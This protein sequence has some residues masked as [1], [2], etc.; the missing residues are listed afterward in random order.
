MTAFTLPDLGEGLADATVLRW[1]VQPG[2]RVRRGDT[3]LDVETAKAVVE[4]PAPADGEVLA[5][6]VNAGDTVP[7]GSVLLEFAE[8]A[9]ATGSQTTR[10]RGKAAVPTANAPAATQ[11][12]AHGADT[13]RDTTG[14]T[15]SQAPDQS[16]RDQ[17]SVVGRMPTAADTRDDSF[18]VGRHRHTEAR[19]Q[20]TPARRRARTTAEAAPE[21]PAAQ[22]ATAT[23]APPRS[24]T[25][26][27]NGHGGAALSPLRARMARQL[28]ACRA[29][30]PVTIF[31]EAEL[32]FDAAQLLSARLLRALVAGAQA[33]PAL[34]A[35]FDGATLHSTP[36]A[37]V[38]VGLAVDTADGLVVPVLRHAE[39]LGLAGLQRRVAKLKKAAHAGTL[40]PADMT[41]AT[42]SLSNFGAIAGR[43]ATPLV[44][45][46]QVAILGAG[47]AY[48]GLRMGR[49]KLKPCLRLPLS[50]SVD[51]R[52]VTGGEAARFLAAVIADLEARD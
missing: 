47:R 6:R 19:L 48:E 37:A 36:Q 3:L 15:A 28:E 5:L 21:A 4:I 42:L 14:S 49:R 31:D 23:S 35:H 10:R 40:A 51:H 26:P 43:F 1:H 8:T 22:A 44:L 2:S 38:H 52:A 16:A 11:P 25:K 13:L 12:S 39:R 9:A 50:L 45:P 20:Q 27:G 7:V 24:R 30:I 17:G 33:E 32:R 18:L 41:G 34:N 46:P 29:V